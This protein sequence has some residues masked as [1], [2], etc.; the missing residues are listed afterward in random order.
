[1]YYQIDSLPVVPWP[2]KN[3]MYVVNM[4]LMF[5]CIHYNIALYAL[6]HTCDMED[7]L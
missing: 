2:K 1:M 5:Q 7:D 4:T 6:V 3:F